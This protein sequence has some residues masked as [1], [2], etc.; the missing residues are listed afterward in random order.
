MK[1]KYGDC[2]AAATATASA[3]HCWGFFEG[4]SKRNIQQTEAELNGDK[5]VPVPADKTETWT[6]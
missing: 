1:E 2:P 4:F 3:P 5:K 6:K